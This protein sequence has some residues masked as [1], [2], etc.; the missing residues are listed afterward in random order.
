MINKTWLNWIDTERN[1]HHWDVVSSAYFFSGRDEGG[2]DPWPSPPFT[3]FPSSPSRK[4]ITTSHSKPSP[5]FRTQDTVVVEVLLGAL[6]KSQKSQSTVYRSLEKS[7]CMSH[8]IIRGPRLRDKSA[9]MQYKEAKWGSQ[10]AE[11]FQGQK[12]SK[13]SKDSRCSQL[14][15]EPL[16]QLLRT[17]CFMDQPDHEEGDKDFSSNS[18]S[19]LSPGGLTWKCGPMTFLIVISSLL[20]ISF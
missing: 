13:S 16:I 2:C 3:P 5:L 18:H 12:D 4:K 1:L 8:N 7:P 11:E 17:E 15:T 19:V 9:S 20:Y 14:L 6:S 10:R